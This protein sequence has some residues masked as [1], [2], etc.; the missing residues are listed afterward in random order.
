VVRFI[1]PLR[2]AC[3]GQGYRPAS[4]GAFCRILSLKM[5]S[6]NVLWNWVHICGIEI[7]GFLN[8]RVC[9]L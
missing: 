7:V 5:K 9:R 8:C 1:V 4:Q 6:P 3:T 2:T